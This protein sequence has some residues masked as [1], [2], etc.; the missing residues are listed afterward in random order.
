[1]PPLFDYLERTIPE[2]GFLV[3]DRLTVADLSVASPF[4]NFAHADCVLDAERYPRTVKYVDAI[5]ARPSF[6]PIVA[7]ERKFFAAA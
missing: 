6:A 3:E 4:V 1:M 5:L 7:G 2:S